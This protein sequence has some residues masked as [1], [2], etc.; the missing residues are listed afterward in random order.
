MHLRRSLCRERPVWNGAEGAC[1]CLAKEVRFPTVGGVLGQYRTRR[2]HSPAVCEF[3][4]WERE[5]GQI[6]E[7]VVCEQN[8]SKTGRKEQ[9]TVV[10]EN[11][12]VER[13]LQNPR[14]A[15]ELALDVDS[16]KDEQP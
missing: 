13:G 5:G 6:K 1:D 16:K 15:V 7:G 2:T 8:A 10:V 4:N 11:M 3:C 14:S 9:T 12:A